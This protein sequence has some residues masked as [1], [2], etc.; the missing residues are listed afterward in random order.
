MSGP[1]LGA[2]LVIESLPRDKENCVTN[3]YTLTAGPVPGCTALLPL[4]GPAS[5]HNSQDTRVER[6]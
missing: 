6:E 4:L 2:A 3:P 5:L 1:R